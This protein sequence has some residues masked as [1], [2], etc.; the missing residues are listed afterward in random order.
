LHGE[1]D[2]SSNPSIAADEFRLLELVQSAGIP[3]AAPRYVD[4]S[5]ELFDI[6]YLVVAFVEGAPEFEPADLSATMRVM[7]EQLAAL[8]SVDW[9]PEELD[10]LPARADAV[11][12]R[13]AA[14][15]EHLDEALS[16][17]RIRAALEA[18]WPPSSVNRPALLHGDYWPGNLLWRDG[19]LAAV[20]DWE[21]AATGDPL[22][23]V[24][25]CRL[26]SL[27]A[28][29]EDAVSA[30]T[31][32]Y[33]ELMPLLDYANLPYWDLYAALQP[34]G[35]LAGWGLDTGAERR[36]KEQHRGFVERALARF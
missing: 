16:E 10:F 17:G 24:G 12:R 20:I 4:T 36:M 28:F 21:D 30:F 14:R 31:E 8:H 29:G 23:D 5:C 27:W 22:A 25:N 35:K 33:R 3:V 26:E 18:A 1:V 19:Q 6:P 32:R 2:R 13:L 34:A 9:S 7:A 15:P 11:A